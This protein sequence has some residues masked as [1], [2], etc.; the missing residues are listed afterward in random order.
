MESLKQ[1]RKRLV[2]PLR[3][4]AK[5]TDAETEKDNASRDKVRALY[6]RVL[7]KGYATTMAKVTG[8]F[9][10]YEA[11]WDD[12]KADKEKQPEALSTLRLRGKSFNWDFFNKAFPVRHSCARF[13]R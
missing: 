9:Q 10:S 2:K 5:F 8:A 4:C 1:R 11:T 3:G 7:E 12:G 6:E 13:A